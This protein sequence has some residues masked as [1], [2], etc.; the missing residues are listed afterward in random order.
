M[1]TLLPLHIKQ[2]STIIIPETALLKHT[3]THTQ[4]ISI[5]LC[6]D[7]F[8]HNRKGETGMRKITDQRLE[9][10]NGYKIKMKNYSSNKAD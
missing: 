5:W 10:R 9:N 1:T 8:P 4:S 6:Q 2:S 7:I 3:H